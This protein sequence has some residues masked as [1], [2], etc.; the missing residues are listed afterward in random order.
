MNKLLV[1]MLS[2]KFNVYDLR[3]FNEK[4]GYA[5]LTQQAHAATVWS[6]NHLP[7]N[8]DVWMTSGGDGTLNLW[9]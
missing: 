1:C 8:R 7:Q 6:A 4:E 2:S 5:Y 9:K 3:T